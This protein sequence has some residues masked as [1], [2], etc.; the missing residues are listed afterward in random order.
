MISLYNLKKFKLLRYLKNKL[1]EL[2]KRNSN[3]INRLKSNQ[4]ENDLIRI[5]KKYEFNRTSENTLWDTFNLVKKIIT[6]NVQGDLV[7]CGVETGHSLVLFQKIIE[8]FNLKN[9]KIYGYDTF[10]GTPQPSTV[11]F[12][13]YGTPLKEQFENRKIN[14]KTSGWNN[15]SQDVVQSNFVNNTKLNNNLKLIKGKV[16]DTLVNEKNLPEKI[17]LL[18]LDTNLYESTKIQLK[19][20]SP[21]VQ[22]GG[23]IIID[24]Y[25]NYSGIKK[26]TDEY[27]EKK[28]YLIKYFPIRARAVVYL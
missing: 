12:N 7:E 26:A 18:K 17:S 8:F 10:E 20:L 23:I 25:F 6:N 16:E 24:N 14:K 19:I 21:R 15:V 27:F 3:F 2:I 5:C 4:L 13:K 1:I 28:K 9:I 22:K 11:D